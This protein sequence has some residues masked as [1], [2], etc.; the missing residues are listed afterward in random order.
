MKNKRTDLLHVSRTY[1]C[2]C[3]FA[4]FHGEPSRLSDFK[5][6]ENVCYPP[7]ATVSTFTQQLVTS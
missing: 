4:D 1:V 2:E 6:N 3:V 7:E 5:E